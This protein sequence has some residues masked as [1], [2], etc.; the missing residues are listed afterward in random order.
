MGLT[1][2]RVRQ[3]CVCLVAEQGGWSAGRDG[4]RVGVES[5]RRQCDIKAGTQPLSLSVLCKM[6]V[7]GPS[8]LM[9]MGHGVKAPDRQQVLSTSDPAPFF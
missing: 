9:V 5:A 4:L 1:R 8:R 3:L 7:N 2:R 6:G